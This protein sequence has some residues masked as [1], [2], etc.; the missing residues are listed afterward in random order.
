MTNPIN[1]EERGWRCGTCGAWHIGLPLDYGCDRPFAYEQ[2]SQEERE[3]AFLSSDICVVEE[4]E[5]Y[6]LRGVIE[7]PIVGFQ[8]H[9]RWGVWVSVSDKS[10]KICMDH[11]DDPESES[12]PPLFGWLQSRLPLYPGTLNLKTNVHLRHELRPGIE[13]GPTEHPLAV[14]QRN[15]IPLSRVQEIAA[16]LV[17]GDTP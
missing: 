17:H 9:F 10:F 15:G 4:R 16:R 1:P 14:E 11:W 13:L 6:F 7:I 2:L 8:D 12:R 5:W 3:R